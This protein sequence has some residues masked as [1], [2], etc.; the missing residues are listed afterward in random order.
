[1]CFLVKK[2]KDHY[3]KSLS[4]PLNTNPD[5]RRR[6]DIEDYHHHLPPNNE[7]QE[8]AITAAITERFTLIQ[9]PPGK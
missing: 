1:M 6:N 2:W 7:K 4:L 5:E 9:G 3:P 8:D